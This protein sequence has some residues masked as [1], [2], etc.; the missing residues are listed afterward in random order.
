VYCGQHVV[1]IHRCLVIR[2]YLNLRSC[3]DLYR[4]CILRRKV[5][6]HVSVICGQIYR[7]TC[8]RC[9]FCCATLCYIVR[10]MLWFGV[11]PFVLLPVCSSHAGVLYRN[12]RNVIMQTTLQWYQYSD[13]QN[14]PLV[15]D[16]EYISLCPTGLT[17]GHQT[18]ALRLG[19]TTRG[20]HIIII[21]IIIEPVTVSVRL[22]SAK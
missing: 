4:R 2:S 7:S 16:Y 13:A 18:Y 17:N 5:I 10:C 8:K 20:D 21:I 6:M 12:G 19:P 3:I 9:Q 15:I 14:L 1:G 22:Y 11:C